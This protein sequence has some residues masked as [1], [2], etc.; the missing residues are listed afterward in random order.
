MKRGLTLSLPSPMH[1]AQ[2]YSMSVGHRNTH[3]YL[4]LHLFDAEKFKKDTLY[5][6][7]GSLP[8]FKNFSTKRM[9]PEHSLLQPLFNW[10]PINLIKKTF[11]LSTQ[12]S[13]TPTS[14]L[15]K[16]TYH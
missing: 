8:S 9:E 14:S 13:R 5:D 3:D 1:L 2:H 16:K 12:H 15:L 4:E 10:L 7:I 11:Q 6:V